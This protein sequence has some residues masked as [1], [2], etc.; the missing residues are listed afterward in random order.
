MT[1]TED[2]LKLLEF[3]LHLVRADGINQIEWSRNEPSAP[4]GYEE[5]QRKKIKRALDLI[6]KIEKIKGLA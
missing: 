6:E 4:E 5:Q 2:E 3:G 1:F